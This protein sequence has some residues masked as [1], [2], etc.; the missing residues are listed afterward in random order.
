MFC[1]WGRMPLAIHRLSW[2]STRQHLRRT[3]GVFDLAFSRTPQSGK[4]A[5]D[6]ASIYRLALSARKWTQN[7]RKTSQKHV[8][9]LCRGKTASPLIFVAAENKTGLWTRGCGSTD[10]L[11]K[12]A[13]CSLTSDYIRNANSLSLCCQLLICHWS[14]KHH[15]FYVWIPL[16]KPAGSDNKRLQELHLFSHGQVQLGFPSIKA[17]SLIRL[18]DERQGQSRPRFWNRLQTSGADDNAARRG[19]HCRLRPPTS[20]YELEVV[21]ACKLAEGRG[22]LKRAS[23]ETKP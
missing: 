16:P 9:A 22:F 8:S 10:I 13:H 23:K 1:P 14:C 2:T 6:N 15:I 17:A 5:R 20:K 12:S 11:W 7:P 18:V 3:K 21:R 4:Q 19:H